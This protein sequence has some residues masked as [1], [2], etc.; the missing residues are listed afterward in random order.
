[1]LLRFA[2]MVSGVAVGLLALGCG[3]PTVGSDDEATGGS[4]RGP[5]ESSS[6]GGAEATSAGEGTTGVDGTTTGDEPE[7]DLGVDLPPECVAVGVPSEVL[8]QPADIV[9]VVDNS[10]SMEFEAAEI[11]DRLNAFS[12]QIIASGIDVR[13]VLVSSYPDDGWGICIDPPLGSGGC[14][15][16][17]TNPPAFLHVDQR[18]G[19]HDAWELVITTHAEWSD[20]TREE[21]S[22][23][24]V[25]VT[26]DTSD[27]G[28]DAFDTSFLMLDPSYAGYFHHSVVCHSNCPSAAGIGT[29]YIDLS[30]LT[31][32]IAADLC[33]QDFQSV[34]DVLTGAVIGESPS[35]CTLAI[36]P[37][38]DGMDFDPDEVNLE[39][40]DGFGNVETIGR[41]DTAADCPNVVD[42]WHYDNVANPTMIVMCPQTCD[43]LQGSAD[44]AINI[45]FGCASVPAG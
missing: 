15:E 28:V 24:L 18:V 44:G 11:Q 19:S 39:F 8:P 16:V 33:D 40:D 13:V 20:V 26:D 14:P 9:F 2:S 37:P 23:H 10:G 43:K 12:S 17:D 41:V 5:A 1:M 38:P 31:G 25:V 22:T 30:A 6:S 7:P 29:N 42:G 3:Q 35:S 36:P 4:T 27:L 32:G 21:A 45:Q 34:F